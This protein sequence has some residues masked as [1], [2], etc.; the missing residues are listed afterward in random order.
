MKRNTKE[1]FD[2]YPKTFDLDL[3]TFFNRIA[4]QEEKHI[5]Y[6]LLLE[7]I[8]LPSGDVL[9]FFNKYRD[10]YNF[11]INALLEYSNF[12]DIKSQQVN[13]L[14]DLMNGFSVYKN[15]LKPKKKL[16]YEAENLYLKL[17]VNSNKNVNRIL[18]SPPR[19]KHNEEI[20]LQAKTLF[21]LREEIF[22]KLV[23]KKIIKSDFDQSS[24]NDYEE[25][26]AERIKLRK[27]KL[28]KTKEK[29]Q[30]IN[31][32]LFKHFFKYQSPS[33]MYNSLSNTK[34]IE[35]H[36]IQVNLIKSSLIDLKTD[37]G[38]TSKDDVNKIEEI[39]EI[40][41]IA[42][43]ILKFNERDQEG[44]GLKI[45]TPIQILIRL[46][47][48]LAQLKAGNNSEKLKN[49]IRQLLYS[50]YRSKKLTT[51]IYKSLIDII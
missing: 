41:D 3:K 11:G 45:L 26:I 9:N 20:Y 46:P 12:N 21:N 22:K 4:F 7:D 44:Q 30:N 27:Q 15:I 36:N 37:I 43:L 16:N 6:N 23:N 5:D 48:S 8:L 38:N 29:E 19:D 39:N 18:I 34:D 24:I 1:F 50:L 40:A 13:F 14:K 35:R 17:M 33:K 32:E 2:G 31:N 49:E 28:D 42:E 47:I 10:L 25:N 51:N